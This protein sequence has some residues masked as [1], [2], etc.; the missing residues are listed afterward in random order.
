MRNEQKRP[1]SKQQ[2]LQEKRNVDNLRV[3]QNPPVGSRA[4]S[5]EQNNRV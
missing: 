4:R 3:I 1:D 5:P 2:V